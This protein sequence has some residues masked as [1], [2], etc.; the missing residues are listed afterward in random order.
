MLWL[1][2][3][4]KEVSRWYSEDNDCLLTRKWL[5]FLWFLINFWNTFFQ[6]EVM[7]FHLDGLKIKL[8]TQSYS[9]PRHYISTRKAA[10]VGSYIMQCWGGRST[11]IFP[12]LPLSLQWIISGSPHTWDNPFTGKSLRK[13]THVKRQGRIALWR[14]LHAP[15]H[16]LLCPTWTIPL[17]PILSS[18]PSYLHSHT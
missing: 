1:E 16:P 18:W 5:Y 10:R 8:S 15:G 6:D 4:E 17:S 13:G 11:Y 12:H 3:F 14:M 9:F 2:L 7:T